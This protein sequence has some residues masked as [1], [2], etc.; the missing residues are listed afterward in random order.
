ML[1]K[2][3]SGNVNCD[4]MLTFCENIF[5]TKKQILPTQNPLLEKVTIRKCLS[6]INTRLT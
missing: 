5:L 4:G 2:N 1:R 6:S 3:K